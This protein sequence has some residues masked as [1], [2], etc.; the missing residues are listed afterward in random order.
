MSGTKVR[1]SNFPLLD[2]LS[3]VAAPNNLFQRGRLG[4]RESDLVSCV[5]GTGHC[6]TSDGAEEEEWTEGNHDCGI[7]GWMGW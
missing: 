1:N 2:V 3:D 6:R 5:V 7:V 4:V